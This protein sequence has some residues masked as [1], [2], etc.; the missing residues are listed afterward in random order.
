M[1]I[2]AGKSTRGLTR[3]QL[4]SLFARHP[5]VLVDIGAGDGK[6]VYRTAKDHPD[7]FCVGVDADLSSL[8]EFSRK[9]ERKPERGGLPNVL[10]VVSNIEDLPPEL[11][12]IADRVTVHL[13][14]GSLLVGIVGA[15]RKVL[16]GLA[17]I[18]KPGAEVEILLGYSRKYEAHEMRR[19]GLPDLNVQFIDK[20]MARGFKD[21]GLRIIERRILTNEELKDIPLTWGRKLAFGRER[22]TFLVRAEVLPRPEPVEGRDVAGKPAFPPTLRQAQGAREGRRCILRFTARGHTN[23]KATHATTFEFTRDPDIGPTADCIIGVSADWRPEDME[24]LKQHHKVKMTISCGG[25]AET[26]KL[27]VNSG[28]SDQSEMVVRKS[29]FRSPRTLGV[30]AD[31]SACQLSRDLAKLLGDPGMEIAVAVE[32]VS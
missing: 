16:S 12:R 7:W 26:V 3:E 9:A 17:R 14:W 10:Y 31:K 11:D 30:S 8:S 27:V 1:R 4:E 29:R 22:Q 25:I 23:I 20:R 13:P 6:F 28:F 24:R 15:H 18:G 32:A 19:R 5:R 21:A 2:A